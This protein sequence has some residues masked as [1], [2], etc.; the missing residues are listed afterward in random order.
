MAT[1]IVTAS[2]LYDYL[3][4]PHRVWRDVYGPKDEK[5]EETNP[6]VQMLWDKGVSY[7]KEVVSRL[8]EYVDIS[9]GSQEERFTKTIQAIREGVP[10]IYQGV[11]KFENYLGI[12]D[13]LRRMPDGRYIPIDIKSGMGFEGA[14]DDN[15][16]DG[17]EGKPKKHYAVQLCLYVRLLQSLGIPNTGTGRI[18]DIRGR[19]VEYNLDSSMGKRIPQTWW[20]FFEQTKNNVKALLDNEV[21]VKPAVAGVCKLC[22]W[23]A[24]CKKW[25]KE[26]EDLSEIFYLGRAKRDAINQDMYI[27]KISD[28]CNVDIDDFRIQKKKNKAFLKGIGESTLEKLVNRARIMSITKRPVSY[29]K[30]DFPETSYE[31]FFDIEDDPMQEF[32]YMHGVYE[33]HGSEERFVHFTA[34]DNTEEAEREAWLQFWNYIRAL[35]QGDFS[36]YYYSHHEWTTYRRMQKQYPDIVTSDEVERFFEDPKTIDL[37]SVVSKY[38]DWPLGSYSLKAIAQYLGFKWR[39]ETPSGALSIQWFNE[40]LNAKDEKILERILLYNEDDCKATMI[41]KDNIEELMNK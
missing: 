12:P 30:F 38:T 11:L 8:D 23:Y 13:L 7:E 14:D 4:C 31:L 37:Y 22:P 3:Q 25:T 34:H 27:E 28:F 24:S 15:G 19:E 1:H 35:P 20:Q 17:S 21:Q 18:I 16:E 2:K 36:V 29:G 5:I 40:F 10:L 41:L 9:S 26:N 39:D 6:F 32:V 33:R